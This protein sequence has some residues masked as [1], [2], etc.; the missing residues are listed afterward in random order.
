MNIKVNFDLSVGTI[1]TIVFII[2]KI[3]GFV[4]WSW[5]WVF[6]PLWISAILGL[7]VLLIFY[8]KYIRSK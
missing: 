4:N 8:I 2:L 6:S 3:I 1:L 5:I 7:I